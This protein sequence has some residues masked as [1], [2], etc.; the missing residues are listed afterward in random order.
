MNIPAI[1]LVVIVGAGVML[2]TWYLSIHQNWIVSMLAGFV[3]GVGAIM[4]VPESQESIPDWGRLAYCVLV[5]L[6]YRYIPSLLG[7]SPAHSTSHAEYSQDTLD[8]FFDEG[9]N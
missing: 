5:G 7:P 9:G 1:A 8:A 4:A 2:A 3:I 6:F